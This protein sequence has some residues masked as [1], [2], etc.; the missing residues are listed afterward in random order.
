MKLFESWLSK[1]WSFKTLVWLVPAIVIAKLFYGIFIITAYKCI[2]VQEPPDS[3]LIT[4]LLRSKPLELFLLACFVG[5]IAE[6]L[7]Y[8]FLPMWVGVEFSRSPYI[9]LLIIIVS[10]VLFGYGHYGWWSLMIQGVGGIVSSIIFLKSG[11][12][13]SNYLKA[14]TTVIILHAMFNTVLFCLIFF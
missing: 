10:S 13:E 5:P 4:Q 11:G 2:G 8:R 12:Y 3:E 14:L 9:L 6:E 7:M 1:Q